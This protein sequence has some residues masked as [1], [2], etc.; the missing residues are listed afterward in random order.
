ME[1]QLSFL[2]LVQSKQLKKLQLASGGF[3][4]GEVG[5]QKRPNMLQQ[6]VM[7]LEAQ[8]E[9]NQLDT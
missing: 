7:T 2:Q 5:V 3:K 8:L 4:V 6:L 1:D 9:E